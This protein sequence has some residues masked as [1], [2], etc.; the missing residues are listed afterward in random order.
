[1]CLT[2]EICHVKPSFVD[3]SHHIPVSVHA[4]SSSCSILIYCSRCTVRHINMSASLLPRPSVRVWERDYM[5]AGHMYQRGNHFAFHNYLFV[6][7][8]NWLAYM[9]CSSYSKLFL[10]LWIGVCISIEYGCPTYVSFTAYPSSGTDWSYLPRVYTFSWLRFIVC[11]TALAILWIFIT[12][13]SS[14]CAPFLQ[15]PAHRWG[16]LP[17][18]PSKYSLSTKWGEETHPTTES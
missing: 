1:M 3:H 9:W 6:F 10:S 18:L 5:S 14:Q 15:C 13:V 2:A 17:R 16:H 12:Q 11:R 4:T 7:F 8:N